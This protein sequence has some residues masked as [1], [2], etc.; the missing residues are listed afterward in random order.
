M[1]DLS[2]PTDGNPPAPIIPAQR[3]FECVWD[4]R[5][6]TWRALLATHGYPPLEGPRTG[7][8]D[9]ANEARRVVHSGATSHDTEAVA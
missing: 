4:R 7:N 1:N 5:S 6:P 9:S 2:T 8:F 3:P